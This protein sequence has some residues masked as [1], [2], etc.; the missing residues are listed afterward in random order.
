MIR[1]EQTLIKTGDLARHIG[2]CVPTLCRWTSQPGSPWR[3]C[4]FRHG[5]YSVPKLR[6]AGLVE[7]AEVLRSVQ[8]PEPGVCDVG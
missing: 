7:S 2:I 8:P 1:P 4:M 3:P 5:W 6:A